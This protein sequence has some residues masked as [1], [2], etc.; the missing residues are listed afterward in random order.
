[1]DFTHYASVCVQIGADL[2]N[3]KGST[4]GNEYMGSPEEVRAFLEAHEI[5]PSGRITQRDVEELHEIRGRLKEV[6]F[7]P[8]QAEAAGLLNELIDEVAAKPYL[9]DHDGQWHF[10]YAPEDAPI[11][12][13][14]AA[15]AAMALAMVVAEFGYER[16]GSCSA[17]DCQDVYVDMS[18]NRS[19][20]Y[21][22]EIC[23]SRMNVAAF[24]ARS[25]KTKQSS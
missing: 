23:S 13:K 21:C 6:F 18:R 19:R 22:N 15:S 12:H 2:V 1:V 7:A 8:N 5:G 14:V 4:S 17:D 10:H 16:L 9:T 25:R 11:A 24:R 3:T 20:R